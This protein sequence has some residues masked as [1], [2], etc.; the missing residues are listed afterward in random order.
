MESNIRS[1]DREV[2]RGRAVG[3]YERNM[4]RGRRNSYIS[5]KDHNL[6]S[7]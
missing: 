5:R 7:G 6:K 4:E 3:E 2:E 1:A